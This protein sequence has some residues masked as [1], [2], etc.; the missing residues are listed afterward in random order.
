M[1]NIDVESTADLLHADVTG[2]WLDQIS[3]WFSAEA[4]CHM[5]LI[6]LMCEKMNAITGGKC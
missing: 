6:M 1:V 5:V 3:A 4:G 2:V